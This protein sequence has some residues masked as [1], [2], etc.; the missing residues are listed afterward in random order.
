MSNKREKIDTFDEDKNKLELAVIRPGHKIMQDANMQYNMKVSTLIRQGSGDGER[1]LLR[2]ELE[3]HMIK[4][5]LWSNDDAVKMERLGIRIRAIELMIQ[6]GGI[7]LS[8]AKN[9]AIEMSQ[10]RIK[11]MELYNKKQQLD[12][13]TVECVAEAYKYGFLMTK[14]VVYAKDGK[15]FFLD[16]DD[17]MERGD[18]VAAID[19]SR[20]LAKM[21]YGTE[22]NINKTL[23][24]NRWLIENKFMNESGR[25]IN[26]DGHFVDQQGKLVNK[27]GAY[28]SDKGDLVDKNGIFVNKDGTFVVEDP[29]PFLDDSGNP[30]VDKTKKKVSSKKK[31]TKGSKKVAEIS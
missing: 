10:L 8:N 16:Y 17:Y 14:C 24:E 1:L 7:K 23:F 2:S 12:S 6:K 18:S 30:I 28:V 11:M 29:K 9:L 20:C 3:D 27:K 19:T 26:E 25:F 5:G 4:T 22:G 31:K 13:A 21:V 15:P